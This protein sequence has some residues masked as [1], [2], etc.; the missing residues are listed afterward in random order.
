MYPVDLCG[1]NGKTS[2]QGVLFDRN[3]IRGLL[4]LLDRVAD[5][6]LN[7]AHAARS[8]Q[9]AIT[10]IS[11]ALAKLDAPEAGGVVSAGP[12]FPQAEADKLQAEDEG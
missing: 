6:V 2:I 5:P 12:F 8:A 9:N 10:T 4:L 1:E 3:E 7:D 11:L